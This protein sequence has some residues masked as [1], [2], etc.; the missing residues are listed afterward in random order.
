[1]IA[2]VVNC[3]Q[4]PLLLPGSTG[5]PVAEVEQLR[6][7]CLAALRDLLADQPTALL[8]VGAVAATDAGGLTEPVSIE[9]GRLLLAEA[10]CPVPIRPVSIGADATPAECLAVGRQLAAAD[11]E[12]DSGRRIGLL[13]MAD[14]SARRGLKAPG[15]ED[16]RAVPFDRTVEAAL[17]AADPDGLAALDAT[18]AAEL[19]VAGRA[20][21]QVLAGAAAGRR[22]A[23]ETYYLGD[24]FGVWYPVVRWY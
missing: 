22:F 14:G 12:P 20:P 13:V 19:L 17:T 9:I 23:A 18:L 5:C 3:P 1:M 8:L 7:A 2:G 16:P 15:Y 11:D 24:P 21:W 6:A 10:G 4:P